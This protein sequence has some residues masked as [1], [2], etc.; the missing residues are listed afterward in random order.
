MKKS[1]LTFESIM[2]SYRL[3]WDDNLLFKNGLSIVDVY[4]EGESIELNFRNYNSKYTKTLEPTEERDIDVILSYLKNKC[5]FKEREIIKKDDTLRIVCGVNPIGSDLWKLDIEIINFYYDES[6]GFDYSDGKRVYRL[7]LDDA[8]D[9]SAYIV[10]AIDIQNEEPIFGF[11]NLE[12]IELMDSEEGFDY[13]LDLIKESVREYTGLI[14][15]KIFEQKGFIYVMFIDSLIVD[16]NT[17]DTI[18][19]SDGSERVIISKDSIFWLV[20]KLM[21]LNGYERDD[22]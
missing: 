12:D 4:M 7:F 13:H 18:V 3:S 15:H 2:S 19:I 22:E 17:E 21:K 6:V 10:D 14:W 8:E 5:N 16:E 1:Q 20:N 11:S 9:E